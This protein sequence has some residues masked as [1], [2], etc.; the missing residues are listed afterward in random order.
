[1][2]VMFFLLSFVLASIGPGNIAATAL[3]ARW[4]WRWRVRWASPRS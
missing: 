1:M 4:G 3:M 2:P